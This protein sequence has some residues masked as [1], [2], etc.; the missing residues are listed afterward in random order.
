[1]RK[2]LSIA[3]AVLV[4]PLCAQADPDIRRFLPNGYQSELFFD[5]AAMREN[6]LWDG[7]ERNLMLRPFFSMTERAAF[8]EREDVDRVRVAFV[9]TGTPPRKQSVTVLEGNESLRLPD[10]GE[11]DEFEEFSIGEH[12]GLLHRRE[13]VDL[14]FEM[15]ENGEWQE[16]P[17]LEA[18]TI[19][20][21]NPRQGLRVFGPEEILQ[22]IL[23]GTQQ[24]G[25][26]HPGLRGI[27]PEPGRTLARI[28]EVR[29]D[30]TRAEWE[31]DLPIPEDW[32]VE[33]DPVEW[34]SL[35]LSERDDGTVV[36]TGRLHFAQGTAGLALMQ[37][38][39]EGKL[40]EVRDNPRL[41]PIHKYLEPLDLAQRERDLVATYELGA[42]REAGKLLGSSM[43][44]S[45]ELLALP[46]LLQQGK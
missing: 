42:A 15:D 14:M 35:S 6:E 10:V 20:W 28:V 9:Y 37:E 16:A 19:L 25:K 30:K 7:I 12:R 33:E 4:T 23:E 1:M 3:A 41:K 32:W 21:L 8:V 11:L 36:A 27:R 38:K 46:F 22:P 40:T 5:L 24:G 31:E 45:P 2:H 29:G 26:A 39:L 18:E 13:A 43:T 44:P 34:M 17:P